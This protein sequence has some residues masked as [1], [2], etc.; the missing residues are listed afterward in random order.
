MATRTS[1]STSLMNATAMALSNR[2]YGTCW[3]NRFSI[4]L[5]RLIVLLRPRNSQAAIHCG[6][7]TVRTVLVHKRSNGKASSALMRSMTACFSSSEG[8]WPG[9]LSGA[10]RNLASYLLTQDGVESRDRAIWILVIYVLGV[11]SRNGLDGLPMERVEDRMWA[12]A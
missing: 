12:H 7:G 4:V 3:A 6:L 11:A 8:V 1:A 5:R 10:S 2:K 9:Q